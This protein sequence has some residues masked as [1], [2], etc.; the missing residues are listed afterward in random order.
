[1][2]N[3]LKELQFAMC[4]ENLESLQSLQ[5]IMLLIAKLIGLLL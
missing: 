5:H 1:M 4:N 3:I 2:Y